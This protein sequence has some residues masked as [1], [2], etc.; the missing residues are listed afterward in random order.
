MMHHSDIRD[1]QAS[2]VW[3]AWNRRGFADRCR[4]L[5][6]ALEHL[7]A[8]AEAALTER[9]ARQLMV[10][11]E[12]LEITLEMPG[13]TGESNELY[14]T[15][16]GVA[17]ILGTEA[18]TE[19]LVACQLLAALACGNA[20]VLRWPGQE[21]WLSQL[22]EALHQ[23]GVPRALLAVDTDSPEP[24]LFSHSDLRMVIASCTPEQ[25]I[26]LNR[27]LS[28]QEGVLLQLVAET[29]L[30]HCPLLTSPDFLLRLVT[31]K[32]RTINTTAVGG[33]A[34]LLELGSRTV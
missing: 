13:P 28:A 23:A 10:D 14:L 19:T 3:E 2:A 15:G 8:H 24:V 32:T 27:S 34:T 7:P 9:L 26:Q 12:A 30:Q 22:V 11:A 31:E 33:N 16:R 29:D 5:T 6:A 1:I 25:E 21:S 18:S 20:V 4:L 17:L